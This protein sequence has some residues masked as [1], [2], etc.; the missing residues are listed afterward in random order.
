V[1]LAPWPGALRAVRRPPINSTRSR[2]IAGHAGAGVLNLK[3]NTITGGLFGPGVQAQGDPAL[4]RE[5]HRI[6]HQVVH[7]LTDPHGVA[8][9]AAGHARGALDA[10]LQALGLDRSAPQAQGL[11]QRGAQVEVDGLDRHPAG[12]DLGVIQQVVQQGLHHQPGVGDQM[13]V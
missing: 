12:A 10:Q 5:L 7:H 3:Q 6:G 1:K 11:G 13:G 4:G 8:L 2:L 9:D